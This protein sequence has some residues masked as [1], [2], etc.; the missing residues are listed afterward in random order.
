MADA[1]LDRRHTDAVTQKFS[2]EEENRNMPSQKRDDESLACNEDHG[3]L[4]SEAQH[5][6]TPNGKCKTSA[7]H[8]KSPSNKKGTNGGSHL[9]HSGHRSHTKA[10]GGASQAHANGIF[11]HFLKSPLMQK[12]NK[13]VLG[14]SSGDSSSKKMSLFNNSGGLGSASFMDSRNWCG[15]SP[16][17][18]RLRDHPGLA[19]A[20][21]NHLHFQHKVGEGRLFLDQSPPPS[22]PNE[23]FLQRADS[24]ITAAWPN[25]QSPPTN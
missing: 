24:T 10:N 6:Q 1:A 4:E 13:G 12:R 22:N 23:M 3:E 19:G 8:F 14:N 21:P 11:S 15:V 9:C 18:T 5:L 17:C 20:V 7:H 25:I 16:V 2:G